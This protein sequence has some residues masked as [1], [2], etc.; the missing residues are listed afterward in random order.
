MYTYRERA[1]ILHLEIG[2]YVWQVNDFFLE[3]GTDGRGEQHVGELHY[4][5]LLG[6][7]LIYLILTFTQKHH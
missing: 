1:L 3:V 4:A 2:R 6:T 7:T 5:T